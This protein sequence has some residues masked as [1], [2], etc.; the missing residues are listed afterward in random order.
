[1][2]LE[3]EIVEVKKKSNYRLSLTDIMCKNCSYYFK[4]GE[5]SLCRFDPRVDF[6]VCDLMRC[7]RHEKIS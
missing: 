5:K 2:L 4:H 1:M 7:D 6:V 3:D